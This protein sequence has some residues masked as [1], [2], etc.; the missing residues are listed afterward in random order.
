[1]KFRTSPGPR[2]G[3]NC[4]ASRDGSGKDRNV[5]IDAFELGFRMMAG[6]QALDLLDP[7]PRHIDHH[8]QLARFYRGLVLLNAG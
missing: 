8:Q 3:H 6:D 4:D 2:D 7:I 1:M 5:R